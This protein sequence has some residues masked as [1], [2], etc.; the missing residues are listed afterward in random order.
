MSMNTLRLPGSSKPGGGVTSGASAIS[1]AIWAGASCTSQAPSNTAKLLAL[2]SENSL[3]TPTA[4]QMS[5]APEATYRCA[6]FSAVL[7]LAQAFSTLVTGM[8][9]MP[10]AFSATW[11]ATMYWPSIEPWPAVAK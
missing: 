3:S 8:P 9:V 2:S 1:R 7:E 11:P 5:P 6:A 4:R 10:I